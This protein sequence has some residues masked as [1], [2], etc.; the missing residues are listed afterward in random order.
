MGLGDAARTVAE[1]DARENGDRA[2]RLV[3][4]QSLLADEEV[5]L[6]G[7]AAQW[8]FEDIKATWIYGYLTATVLAAYAFC[9][10]QLAGLVRM[11]P[12]DPGLR[13]EMTSLEELAAMA[14]L[15]GLIDIDLHARLLNLHDVGTIYL[16]VGLHEY[17]AQTE[18]RIV[19][20]ESFADDH[21]LLADAR[22]ALTCSAALLHRRA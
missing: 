17:S 20:A 10:H 4:L 13:D 18:R 15:R 2:E 3:E 7:E 14:Q 9:M 8:L 11:F 19:E 1:A 5:G 21:P 12:D 22:A 16:T 6:S